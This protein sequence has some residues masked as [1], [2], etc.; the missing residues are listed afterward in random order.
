MNEFVVDTSSFILWSEVSFMEIIVDKKL[1]SIV[2]TKDVADELK[3][4][5]SLFYLNKGMEKGIIKIVEVE[6]KEKDIIS[7][8][9]RLGKGEISCIAFCIKEGKV[10]VTDDK[11]AKKKAEKEKVKVFN[12][13]QLIKEFIKDEKLLMLIK[14]KFKKFYPERFSEL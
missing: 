4:E 14:E 6:N 11:L 2:L 9:Y 1:F 13:S 8:K 10:L 5:I 7:V 12:T 3:D